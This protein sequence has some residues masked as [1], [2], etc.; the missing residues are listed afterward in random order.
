MSKKT[1]TATLFCNAP[2][3]RILVLAIAG[4]GTNFSHAQQSDAFQFLLGQSIVQDSNLFR[5]SDGETLET[6]LGSSE[7][8]ETIASTMLGFALDRK[9]GRQHI[10][11]RA[12]VT[13]AHFRRFSF[14][15]HTGSAI[16]GTW[17][18]ELGSRW[19][20]TA[21]AERLVKLTDFVDLR[22]PIKNLNTYERLFA[23]SYYRWHPQWSFGFGGGWIKST[24]D[25]AL[26][27]VSDYEVKAIELG[28]L[29]LPRTGNQ[30]AAKLRRSVSEY[31]TRQVVA[32]STIDNS[33]DQYDFEVA[34]TWQVTG[35]TR[36]GGVIGYTSRQHDEIRQRD[37]RGVIGR[38]SGDWQIDGKTS[39]GVTIRREIDAQEDI[40]A[41]YILTQGLSVSPIWSITSKVKLMG[42]FDYR[43]RDFKGDPGFVISGDP[44]RNDRIRTVSASMAYQPFRPLDIGLTYQSERRTSNAPGIDYRHQLVLAS[45]QLAF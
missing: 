4:L 38:V 5:L 43:K 30:V 28:A 20:G 40:S 35:A 27:R 15:D 42:K 44:Q 37:F 24:N 36:L 32:F 3:V 1:Q 11:A 33:Y 34:S 39:V 21:A 10:D 16:N 8:D 2:C 41:N 14:L 12:V 7:R 25:A 9:Y 18:W 19:H 26:R 23:D 17:R 13:R 31:P 45:F 6:T 29:F 22:A